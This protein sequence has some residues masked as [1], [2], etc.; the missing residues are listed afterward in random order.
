MQASES[1]V[2]QLGYLVFECAPGVLE[3]MIVVYRDILGAAVEMQ[4]DGA[5]HVRLDGRGFRLR[6]EPGESNRLAA[7]GWEVPA[8]G[9]DALVARVAE[10][11]AAL[12]DPGAAVAG[13]RGI[14]GRSRPRR[15]SA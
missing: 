3:P 13:R 15:S 2:R 4:G 11:G 7:I 14:R 12:S 1:A 10:T 8:S 6:L 9:F 5:A